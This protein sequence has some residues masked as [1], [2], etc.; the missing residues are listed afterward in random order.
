MSY[1]FRLMK[2]IYQFLIIM[3]IVGN[4]YLPAQARFKRPLTFSSGFFESMNSNQGMVHYSLTMIQLHSLLFDKIADSFK[5]RL[6]PFFIE[7]PL[8]Y[9]LIQS[10]SVPFHEF[11]HARAAHAVSKQSSYKTYGWLKLDSLN[12][13]ELAFICLLTPPVGFPGGGHA[14]TII[15]DTPSSS[16]YSEIKDDLIMTTSG[17]N[18]QSFLASQ[19]AD[20]IYQN[21]GHLVYC[22]HYLGNKIQHWAYA[23]VDNDQFNGDITSML[24][25]YKKLSI[26]IKKRD[27][28]IFSLLSVCSGTTASLFKSYYTFLKYGN[29]IVETMEWKKIRFPDL[30]FYI[31]ASGLSYEIVSGYRFSPHLNLQLATEWVFKGIKNQLQLTPAIH[32]Q[33]S[34][35]FPGIPGSLWLKAECILAS[36]PSGGFKIQWAPFKNMETGWQSLFFETQ[37][38]YYHADNLYGERNIPK[39]S[40]KKTAHELLVQIGYSI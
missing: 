2:L 12:F 3:I 18:N 17:L 34:S 20:S 35:D 6:V 21:Q 38:T 37:Y 33:L 24:K 5:N 16:P 25:S 14:V 10:F 36:H 28:Q 7:L 19:I 11:G 31:N 23:W 4:F 27:I 40:H 15:S 22:G 8:G 32:Y 1:Y 26:P 9:W 29:P 30:N 39:V 13:W